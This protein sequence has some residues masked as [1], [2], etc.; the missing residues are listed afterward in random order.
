VT[1]FFVI[2][3]VGNGLFVPPNSILIMRAASEKGEGTISGVLNTVTYLG[4]TIGVVLF[5]TIFSQ[6]VHPS[7]EGRTLAGPGFSADNL[8]AGFRYVFCLLGLLSVGGMVASYL[9]GFKTK[10][11]ER[12][13]SP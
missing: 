1:A 2:R 3:A 8:L 12:E 6:V 5:E 7:G 4:A 11:K 13:G 9:A 10:T